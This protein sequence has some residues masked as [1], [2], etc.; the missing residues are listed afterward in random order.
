MKIKNL[1]LVPALCLLSVTVSFASGHVKHH[2]DPL[3]K[4]FIANPQQLHDNE[5]QQSLR[6]RLVWQ[7]F[8]K[9]NGQWNVIFDESSGMPHRAFG[10]PVSVPGSDARTT[11]M[12]FMNNNLQEFN[13]P[14]A[15]LKFRSV[16]AGSKYQYVNF[17]QEHQGLEI[18]YSHVQIK[19]MHDYRVMQFGLDCY[20][21]INLSTQ[22]MLSDAAAIQFASNNVPGILNVTVT[23]NL[24]VLPVP[25]YH[26][27]TFHLVYEIVVENRDAEGIPGKYYTLV[28]ANTG[29]ILYRSNQVNHIVANTDVNVSGTL[30]LTNPY[31]PATVEPLQNLKVVESGNTYYTDDL[32]FLGLTNTSA[33][34]ATFS[35]EG[36][37]VK[38]ET[39][40]N[41]PSWTVNLNP[42]ANPVNIDANAD[43]KQRTTYNSIND[44]HEYMKSKYP[45]FTGLD[46]AL[47]ANVDVAGSCNA[48]YDGSSVNFFAAGG[49]C[50]ATSLV[51]DVCYHEYGHAINDKFY[52]SIGANFQ[53]GAMGEGYADLWALGI[54]ASPI[55]GIGFFDN[56]PNGFVR[57]YDIDKKV[58]PQDLVGEVHAD[59][60]I[61]AGAFWDTYLNLGNLQQMMDLFKE[62]F[63][64]GISDVDGTEG[65][66]FQDILL[67][68]LTIDD[69]DGD[70]T[71]GTPNYCA[72]TSGFAIHGISMS[73]ASGIDHVEVLSAAALSPITVT[74]VVQTLG[75]GSEVKGYY[76]I[77]NTGTWTLFSLPN[78]TG[79]NYEGT[80]PGQ[81]NG[82]IVEYYMG[83]EDDCGT[84]LN[85]I[86]GG[87]AEANPN[88][89]YYILVGFNQLLFED[90]D[91]FF[92]NWIA[93]IPSDDATTGNWIIDEPIESFVGVGFVQPDYQ[94]TPGGQFCAITG[95]ASSPSAGAGE[96]DVDN[97]KTTL[98]SPD[99]DL[100]SYTN[101]AITFYRWYSNDQGAT[102]GTDFWQVA[103]SGDGI[104]YVPVENTNV[105]DHS[106]RR[107]AFKVMDYI[108]PT[109]TVTVRF[110][111]EDA[112]AGSLVEALMDDI[113]VWDEI[114][115]SLN[116]TGAITVFSVYPN[117]ASDQVNLNIGLSSEDVISLSILNNL[118]QEVYSFK[119]NMPAGNNLFSIDTEGFADGL[120]QVKVSGTT[121]SQIRKLN[122]IK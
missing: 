58:Y 106:W 60:E 95:N 24:K 43:L 107:F 117:P 113:A 93:G 36:K 32:G 26:K 47:T 86:P 35:L 50:N 51:V 83:I 66:L 30:H 21:N 75:S 2:D 70:I 4:T 111:A 90:F 91:A 100:A 56:D 122:V 81:P 20:N 63:Y 14:H 19:M 105:G 9:N 80:I 7:N 103:V 59:G 120:Y 29:A 115:L 57:R 16:A 1:L 10:K 39:F 82:T 99:F 27:Y 48:F 78:T 76:R 25:G 37:W 74:S 41:T 44:V 108:T 15:S 68:T 114:P 34:T 45:L 64:A 62:T 52:Q 98:I 116:E 79:N 85:I 102:P 94:N 92:G 101:P 73:A 11:A 22:P 6:N 87:A 67:E 46:Y 31:D 112:N 40:N 121:G 12:N 42:G 119:E 110:I 88:I 23:P 5:Y 38:V 55:L 3:R 109:A 18:L 89:P 8:V 54:T 72:I 71:N 97:G 49:G 65:Q 13:I 17:Y 104:T 69:N 53:N 77:G 84:F 118:G 33:T 96:N 61:I 28:D